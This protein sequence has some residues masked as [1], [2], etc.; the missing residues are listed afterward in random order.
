MARRVLSVARVTEIQ[1]L[2]QEGLSDRQIAK[3]L[4]CRRSLVRKIRGLGSE[5]VK[6]LTTEPGTTDPAWTSQVHWPAILDEMGR[7]FEIKRI[8]EERAAK[9]TGYSNFWKY[10]K[11]IYPSLMS[12]TVTLRE[13]E[14]GTHCEVDWAGD[15]I[16]WWNEWGHQRRAHVFVG[17]LCHSQMI[18]ACATENE[19]R[20]NWLTAHEKMY[21]FFGGVPRVTVPDNP[22]TATQ[23]AHRYDPDLN[24]AYAEL[25]AHYQTA[26]VP[27]RVR[28]P[29]DKALVENA[30]GLVMRLL[31]WKSRHR[32]FH[33]LT[34]INE[35][36]GE[37]VCEINNKLHSRLRVSRRERWETVEKARL[38]ALPKIP[39]EQVEWK[40]AR[41]HPDSTIAVESAF[42]SVP[43][44]HR[45]KEVRVKLTPRQVEVYVGLERVALHG[46]DRTRRGARIILAEH[47]PPNAQAYREATPRNLLS[48]ARFISAALHDL[49]DQLF[50]EDALGHLRRAQGL[51]RHARSE[52]TRY[53]RAEAEVRIAEAIRQMRRFDKV[54]VSFFE[55]V[56]KQLRA[57]V[58]Q[59]PD[60]DRII[61]RKPGNPMLRRAYAAETAAHGDLQ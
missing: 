34:E 14:P 61:Q 4:C 59:G 27:A 60:A 12:E 13:F 30:V 37:A 44:A 45:G 53:G 28:S 57:T 7:G 52:L 25:A 22:K 11:K 23:K 17:I 51:I 42:Y 24:P 21:S 50:N 38:K 32:R 48:Q 58:S 39:F 19:Q 56:L 3:A 26:V 8:W 40:S 18:F 1:R 15:T 10:L 31:R 43:H 2:I 49:V 16:A 54:R 33:S 20:V 55:E 47:L 5:A 36:L 29:R 9:V 35:A 41:V 6:A 46:R